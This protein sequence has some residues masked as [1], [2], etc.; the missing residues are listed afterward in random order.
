M[1]KRKKWEWGPDLDRMAQEGSEP[2]V[3]MQEALEVEREAQE[4][5]D[6]ARQDVC[7]MLR[8]M[9]LDRGLSLAKA[10]EGTPWTR[11]YVHAFE[12]GQRWSPAMAT[13]LIK[14]YTQGG[15]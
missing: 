1:R 10:S 7:A 12:T 15:E 13:L 5:I 14:T 9:R 8:Q 3:I 11:A 6:A 2:A 4:T